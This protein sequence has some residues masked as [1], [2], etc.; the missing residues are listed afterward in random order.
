ML[1]QIK[2]TKDV[3]DFALQLTKEGLSFHPDDD[4]NNYILRKTHEPFYTTK[5]AEARNE[6]MNQ[7]FL[8]C[9]NNNIDIYDTMLEVYLKETKLDKF[10]PL[11][12]SFSN[13]K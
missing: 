11:P 1:A 3:E 12:S 10:I 13:E 9:K 2:T 5:E 6:L 8:V 7:S 4:F